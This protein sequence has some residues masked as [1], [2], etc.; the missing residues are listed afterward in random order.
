MDAARRATVTHGFRNCRGNESASESTQRKTSWMM[1][2]TIVTLRVGG[3]MRV[4]TRQS[5]LYDENDVATHAK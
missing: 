4:S 5:V 2:R 3:R 1:L